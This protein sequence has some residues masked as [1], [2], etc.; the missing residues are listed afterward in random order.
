MGGSYGKRR[1]GA[2]GRM[3]AFSFNQFKILSCG[4]GGACITS[5]KL[6][7][8]RAFMAHDGGCSV[9]PETG[10]M[11]QCFFCGE[12]FRFNEISAAIMR[13]Q[14][15]RLDGILDR[16]RAARAIFQQKL[17]LP[18]GYRVVKSNDEAG[19]CGVCFLIQAASLDKALALETIMAR[20]LSV[21]RPIE[22]GRHV[23]SAWDVVN[24]KAGGHHPEWDCFRHPKNQRVKTNY[25]RPMKRTDD[26]LNRTVLCGTPYGW[27]KRKLEQT[28]AAINKELRH[29]A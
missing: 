14:L 12:N 4:E 17:E 19:N 18:A 1:L 9:W 13:T 10:E 11:S 20:H 22:S 8:E 15:K 29:L 28:V 21:H 27:P 25:D 16:L 5:E 23:Y 3:A 7:A 2:W 6:L 24:S 26:Y